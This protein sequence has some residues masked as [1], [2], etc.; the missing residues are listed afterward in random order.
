MTAR[1]RRLNSIYKLTEG[2]D[3]CDLVCRMAIR[4]SQVLVLN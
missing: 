4:L 1:E 2:Y 3:S